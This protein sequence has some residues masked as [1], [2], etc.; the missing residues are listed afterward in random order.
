[1]VSENAF[2]DLDGVFADEAELFRALYF[3]KNLHFLLR[4][5]NA[6]AP[7]H[8]H[9]RK[10][11][12]LVGN[13]LLGHVIRLNWKATRI[14]KGRGIDRVDENSFLRLTCNNWR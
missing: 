12:A 2:D 13:Y 5:W 10:N 6:H 3:F 7:C 1:M 9:P 14:F 4:Q 8:V 11:S